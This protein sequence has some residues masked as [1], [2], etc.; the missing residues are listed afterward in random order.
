[1]RP[2][3][4][5]PGN[6]SSQPK[7]ASDL[8]DEDTSVGS[9]ALTDSSKV[10]GCFSLASN[11]I[12]SPMGTSSQTVHLGMFFVGRCSPFTETLY[13][14]PDVGQPSRFTCRSHSLLLAVIPTFSAPA[15]PATSWPEPTVPTRGSPGSEAVTVTAP[16]LSSWLLLSVVFS[17][18][19]TDVDA[20]PC[21]C[22]SASPSAAA[23]AA[24]APAPQGAR[25]EA[26]TV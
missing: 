10:L 19:Q 23:A 14:H 18:N 4:P 6:K 17:Y 7:R 26:T 21:C 9:T 24:V 20:G 16:P 2:A 22:C 25:E 12:L 13:A 5:K 8:G 3:D 11:V 1:M 15:R